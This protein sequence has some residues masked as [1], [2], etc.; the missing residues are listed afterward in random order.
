MKTAHC[1]FIVPALLTALLCSYCQAEIPSPPLQPSTGPGGSEYAHAGVITYGP[2]WAY[3]LGTGNK[4]NKYY[5][6]VPDD[7]MP[8]KAPVVLFLHGWA[9]ISLKQYETWISHI[10]R[11]G[12]IVVWVQY[13]S[14][15]IA[16]NPRLSLSP[17]FTRKITVLWRDALTRIDSGSVL[18]LPEKN[19]WGFIKTAI[20]GHSAGGY[21]SAIVA[22]KAV[23]IY[24]RIPVP[25]AVVA[26]E[27]GP[28]GIIPGALFG[29]IN[30]DT[31]VVIVV[32]DEDT[33]N[34]TAAATYLWNSLVQIP[35]ENK[36]FLLVPSDY[37]GFPQQI[38]NHFFPNTSGVRDT[39]AVDGR[40]FYVTFKLSVGALNCAFRGTD[41]EY[42]LGN[43]SKEQVYMGEWSDGAPVQP[44]VWIEKPELL[45]TT[46]QNFSLISTT[47]TT[48]TPETGK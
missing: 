38:S 30:P 4:S 41:C 5:L 17:S 11:K 33:L 31:K 45:E 27:P 44:M 43:G 29:F 15:D 8:D 23:K 40:D 26:V 22:A 3:G 2:Y 14:D 42:A 32:G 10:V 13:Q 34:C 18:V 6:F 35:D 24:K 46:C 47:T 25:Y 7:P 20:V 9:A 28:L 19:E 21:L 1:F 48:A 37:H 39:A 16:D 12:Y 36:D